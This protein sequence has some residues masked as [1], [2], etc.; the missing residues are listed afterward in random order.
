MSVLG[1]VGLAIVILSIIKIAVGIYHLCKEKHN[2]N[3]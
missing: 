1:I 3:E 2:A